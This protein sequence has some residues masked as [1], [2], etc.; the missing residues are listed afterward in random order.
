M[1]K[2][3]LV[4]LSG[5]SHNHALVEAACQLVRVLGANLHFYHA[6]LS[7]YPPLMSA[8]ALVLENTALEQFNRAIEVQGQGILQAAKALAAGA[9]IDCELHCEQ[10]D[11]PAEGI[12]ACAKACGC[13]LIFM[14]SHGRKALAALLLGSQTQK[15]LALSPVPVL[16]YKEAVLAEM[17]TELG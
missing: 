3:L 2:Q 7:Y 14:A 12:V 8:E 16:V 1:F 9:G 10:H 13:D 4:P 6:Q 11:S 17:A 15:V 5:D